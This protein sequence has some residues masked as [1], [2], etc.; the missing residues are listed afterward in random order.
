VTCTVDHTS[1]RHGGT[2]PECFWTRP[3]ESDEHNEAIKS[4][5]ERAIA[6]H[7]NTVR[8]SVR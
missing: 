2:C 8:R 6:N 5:T 7:P 4:E 1:I 3:S